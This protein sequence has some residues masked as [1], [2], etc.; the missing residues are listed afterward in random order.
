ME[1]P[2]SVHVSDHVH[3]A[4]QQKDQPAGLGSLGDCVVGP[5]AAL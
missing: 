4:D 3:Q 1:M 2:G 5:G